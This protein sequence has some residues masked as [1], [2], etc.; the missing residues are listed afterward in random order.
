M[1]DAS[2]GMGS[3]L[4]ALFNTDHATCTVLPM[5]LIKF[6]VDYNKGEVIFVIALNV[7]SKR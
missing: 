2:A 6:R 1:T 7:F 3:D 5:N 4:S